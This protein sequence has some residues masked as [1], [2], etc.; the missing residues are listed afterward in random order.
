[1]HTWPRGWFNVIKKYLT[2]PVAALQ[3]AS[4]NASPKNDDIPF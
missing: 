3:E 1:M 2:D 4:M